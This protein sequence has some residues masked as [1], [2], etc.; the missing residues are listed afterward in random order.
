MKAKIK[1]LIVDDASF[2][3]RAIADM[4]ATDPDIEVVGTAK[5]GQ[6]GLE[7]VVT[8]RPDVVTLD[9][10]MPLMDGLTSIRHLMIKAPVPIVVLSSLFNDGAITFDAL[11]LGVVDFVPKPSGAVS[12]DI[13]KARKMIIDRIKIASSVNLENIRRVQL[14]KWDVK[15]QLSERYGFAP[16]EYLLTVGT[17]LS[18][19]NTVIRLMSNLSPTLPA[20]VVVVQEISPKII[21]SFIKRFDEHVP[22][23]I[24]MAE[25]GAILE[26]GTCYIH[27]NERSLRIQTDPDGRPFLKMGSSVDEPLDLLFSSAAEAFGQ[28]TIGLMLTGIGEDG[29][30]GF[31]EIRERSGVTLAQARQCC[32]YPNLTDNVIQQDLADA[33]LDEKKLPHTIHDFC[34]AHG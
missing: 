1:V 11:R 8:L 2:M 16:L 26:Q 24:E 21:S 32:V 27:S 12:T 10:D 30:K 20:A 29:A 23:K 34:A 13:D 4:L 19:P 6:E 25:E 15:G 17:S 31:H 28:N 33:V 9:I 18:G 7:K 22:W 14:K 3:R 5:N